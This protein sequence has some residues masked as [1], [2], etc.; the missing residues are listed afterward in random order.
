MQGVPLGD[1]Q[2]PEQVPPTRVPM[3]GSGERTTVSVQVVHVPDAEAG[4]G[5]G[6]REEAPGTVPVS[7]F[8]FRGDLSERDGGSRD[9]HRAQHLIFMPQTFYNSLRS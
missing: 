6:A 1:E 7:R 4:R 9:I 8:Y 2:Q 5:E 3:C